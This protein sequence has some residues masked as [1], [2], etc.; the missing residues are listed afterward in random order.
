[1]CSDYRT[2]L[3][4]SSLYYSLELGGLY[5]PEQAYRVGG[6]A[7]EPGGLGTRYP[8]WVSEKGTKSSY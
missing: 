3:F 5:T 7:F 6:L 2:L 1:V 8:G 4:D